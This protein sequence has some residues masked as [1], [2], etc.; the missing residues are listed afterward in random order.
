M[1]E[2]PYP[3]RLPMRAGTSFGPLPVYLGRTVRRFGRPIP[4]NHPDSHG[5]LLQ[6]L[7]SYCTYRLLRG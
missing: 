7:A 4:S 5:T 3:G 6:N 2:T 1:M